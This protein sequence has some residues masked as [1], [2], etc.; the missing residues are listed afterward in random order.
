MWIETGDDQRKIQGNRHRLV[1]S[2]K[3]QTCIVHLVSASYMV[4]AQLYLQLALVILHQVEIL[5]LLTLYEN[6]VVPFF[7]VPC[8]L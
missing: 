4:S 1:S 3:E 5:W 2:V 8:I 6:L 7:Y